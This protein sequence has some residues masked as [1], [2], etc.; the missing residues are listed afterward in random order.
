MNKPILPTL[1]DVAEAAAVSTATVSRCLNSPDRVSPTTRNKVLKIIREIGYSPNFGARALAAKRTNTYGAIV[2]TMNN[3]L[4]AETLHAFQQELDKQ[5]ATLIVA[6]SS[7]NEETEEDQIRMLVARG[8]DGLLLIGAQ[9][10]KYIYHFLENR[11]TPYVITWCYDEDD[12]RPYV[13]FDNFQAMYDLTSQAIE[14]GHSDFAVISAQTESNDRAKYRVDGIKAA[15]SASGLDENKMTVV[16]T[17]YSITDGAN[18]FKKIWQLPNKPTIVMCGNDV[19]A[20]GAIMMAKKMGIDVPNDISI[21]GFDN[22]EV[23]SVVEPALTTVDVPNNE[24]G[25]L[26]AQT[27][28]KKVSDPKFHDIKLSTTIIKRDSLTVPRKTSN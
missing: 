15:L 4:F 5:G 1:E 19:L 24:M 11:H 17:S 13:G 10:N 26:A 22:L 7:F 8:A 9:R 18:S 25:R 23:S 21:T 12:Q 6:S 2:P 16:E 3:A 20:V 28:L 14:L 27:L